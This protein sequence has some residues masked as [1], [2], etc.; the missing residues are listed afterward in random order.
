MMKGINAVLLLLTVAGTVSAGVVRG[1]DAAQ[2]VVTE[3]YEYYEVFG[4]CEK[5]VQ[6]DLQRKCITWKDGKKYDSVTNWKIKW[7]YD[8]NPSAQNCSPNSF[9]VTVDV[10]FHLPKWVPTKEAPRQL[11]DKWDGYMKNV[12][13]HEKGHRDIAVQAAT[14]L[15]RKVAQLPSALACVELERAIHDLCRKQMRILDRNEKQYDAAT[16]HGHTQGAI[17]P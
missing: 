8:H 15:T 12:L 7:D 4:G 10:T 3:K 2:P 5:D 11:V 17:F 14:E 13:A 1:N 6:C 16:N 9:R